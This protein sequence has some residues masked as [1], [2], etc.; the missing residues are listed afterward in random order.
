MN[1]YNKWD[2][3]V[4]KLTDHEKSILELIVQGK[5]NSE[6]GMELGR[7]CPSVGTTLV[8]IRRKLGA[9]NTTHAAVIAVRNNL[10]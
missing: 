4:T 1:H 5:T 9:R 3:Q 7:S 10:L 8:R 2:L 6:I